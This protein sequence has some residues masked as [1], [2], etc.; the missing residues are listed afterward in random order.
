[1]RKAI[2]SVSINPIILNKL[3]N[4]KERKDF[5]SMSAFVE[6][7]LKEYL[8]RSNPNNIEAI[9]QRIREIMK[10]RD[11]DEINLNEMIIMKEDLIKKQNERKALTEKEELE[12]AEQKR[13]KREKYLAENKEF[14][15]NLIGIGDIINEFKQTTPKDTL[16][17]ALS[18]VDFLREKNAEKI[19]NISAIKL[20]DY[21]I[22]Y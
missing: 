21:L 15:S 3:E 18:K 4:V 1:M 14:Y 9:E 22:S 17:F 8:E 7:I 10:N 6:N 20:N 13:I 19:R 11:K 5:N 2:F 12:R 16:K